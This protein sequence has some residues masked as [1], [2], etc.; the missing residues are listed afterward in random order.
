VITICRE[1]QPRQEF[2]LTWGVSRMI[3]GHW[4]QRGIAYSAAVVTR[5][6]DDGPVI[7]PGLRGRVALVTGC[8]QPAGIGV[9]IA[10][11]LA[12]QGV[13]VA[14]VVAPPEAVS[15]GTATMAVGPPRCRAGPQRPG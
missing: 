13:V 10:R 4:S 15:G 7:D 1:R 9:A 2:A 11:A 12:A 5:A 6:G 14:L 3:P 8:N